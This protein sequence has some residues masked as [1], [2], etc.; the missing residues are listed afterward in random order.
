MEIKSA[1]IKITRSARYFVLGDS[2]LPIET[3]IVVLHGYGMQARSFIGQ[4]ESI[5]KP[6]VLVVAPEG[7]SRFYRKG[8]SG[9]VVASWMTSEE[10]LSEIEDYVNY[11]DQLYDFLN[12]SSGTKTIVLGF[13]QGAAAAS[14]WF[15]NGKTAISEMI[16]WCGEFANE[17]VEIPAK[18]PILRYVHATNDEFITPEQYK[19]QSARMKQ[20]FNSFREYSFNGT[21][22]IDQSMLKIVMGDAGV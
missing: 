10:R 12:I 7:L 20:L 1:G 3:L 13:S 5:M 21:H 8:F 9:D 18:Q 17:A 2:T 11:L 16:I 14:R 19:K 4:F 6:G 22:E 15:M